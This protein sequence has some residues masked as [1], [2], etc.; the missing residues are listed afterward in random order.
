MWLKEKKER[1]KEVDRG[2]RKVIGRE[3]LKED[4]EEERKKRKIL[5]RNLGK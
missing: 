3:K 5:E 4:G 1:R 2:N